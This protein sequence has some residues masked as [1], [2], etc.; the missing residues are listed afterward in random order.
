M[1]DYKDIAGT[2]V[3][4][5]SSDPSDPLLG[6]VWYNTTSTTLKGVVN[7]TAAWASGGNLNQGRHSHGGACATKD[8]GILFGGRGE[9]PNPK[10]SNTESYNGTAWSEVNNLGTARYG[11]GGAGTATAGLAFG[12]DLTPGTTTSSES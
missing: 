12:G 4:N 7:Q 3:Q 2:K 10:T 5:F 8:S 9:P 6:Q 11:L 1:A